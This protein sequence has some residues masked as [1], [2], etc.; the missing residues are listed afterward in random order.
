MVRARGAP[1]SRPSSP[2]SAGDELVVARLDRLGRDTRD[3]LNIIHE[4]EQRGAFVTVLDPHVSTQ[5][6][7]G[8]V[9]LTVLVY[10]GS[11]WSAAS[12]RSASVRALS[13]PSWRVFYAGGKRRLDR[14]RIQ[15][16][17]AGAAARRYRAGRGL[18][19]YAGL[20]RVAG[21]MRR[22]RP[23]MTAV[24]SYGLVCCREGGSKADANTPRNRRHFRASGCGFGVPL[25][26]NG[27]AG[28]PLCTR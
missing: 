8:H 14:A 25:N 1:N 26:R 21:R 13:G 2:S 10:G 3:V 22:R 18:L 4:V 17:H 23:R 7:M 28:Q 27:T 5:G 9:M 24:G 12:S 15:A 20:S 19:S 11:L 16:L 6:P